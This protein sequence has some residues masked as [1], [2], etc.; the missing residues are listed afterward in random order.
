MGHHRRGVQDH[1]PGGIH[2]DALGF[3]VALGPETRYRIDLNKAVEHGL[4]DGGVLIHDVLLDGMDEHGAE[5]VA[6]TGAFYYKFRGR[7]P[8]AGQERLDMREGRNSRFAGDWWRGCPDR[9]CNSAP[10]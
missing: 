3:P 1:D 10:W 8:S 6:Q 7:L 2:G 9:S 4:S 5:S